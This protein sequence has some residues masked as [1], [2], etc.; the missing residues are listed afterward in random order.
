MKY[1]TTLYGHQKVTK[2][3]VE[4]ENEL[5]EIRKEKSV[6]YTRDGD[7]TH[8]NPHYQHLKNQEGV[9]LSKINEYSNILSKIELVEISNRDMD[10]VRIGS[11]ITCS[12]FDSAS[13]ET[14]E[15]IFEIVGYFEDYPEKNKISYLSPIGK[16]LLGLSEDESAEVKLPQ[17]IITLT[18]LSFHKEF[19]IIK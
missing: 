19:P 17:K 11:I 8:D 4:L 6:A 3:I 5:K 10:V 16:A 7:G 18:V 15:K 1:Y 2:K 9:I 13:N 12:I 14:N